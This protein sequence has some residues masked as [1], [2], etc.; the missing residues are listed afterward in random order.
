MPPGETKLQ[1]A[2]PCHT[3]VSL[4]KRGVDVCCFRK[5]K[6][7]QTDEITA[8][9]K[10]TFQKFEYISTC[11]LYLQVSSQVKTGFGGE[12]IHFKLRDL[13]RFYA[14]TVQMTILQML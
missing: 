5:Q 2:K 6:F 11:N 10:A 8:P 9:F 3:F 13:V 12:K 1:E 4:N 14:Y 7:L